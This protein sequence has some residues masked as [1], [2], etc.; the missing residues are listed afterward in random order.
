MNSRR[1]HLLF[2]VLVA[3]LAASAL[4]RPAAAAQQLDTIVNTF[5]Q[6]SQT[7]LTRATVLGMSAYKVLVALEVV[8]TLYAFAFLTLSGKI[9]MGGVL[10]TSVNKAIVISIGLVMLQFYPLFV[11]KILQT[12]TDAGSQLVGFS[13][14]TPSAIMGQGLYLTGLLLYHANNAGFIFAGP[15]AVVSWACGTLIFVCFTMIAWRLVMILVEAA[16]LLSGGVFF[17]G[18]WGSRLTA[19]LAENYLVS[20]TR[21]GIHTYFLYLVVAVGNAIIPVWTDTLTQPITSVDGLLPLLNVCGQ[22]LI[23][24]LITTKLPQRLAHELTAPSSFLHLR[25]AISAGA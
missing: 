1:I 20:L 12:F 23:F 10:A 24:T 6:A 11:P 19:P 8:M 22:V 2:L 18:F 13:G 17:L 7:A 15:L 3:V 4:P 25:N 21:L 9:T 16:L 14:I 5:Q